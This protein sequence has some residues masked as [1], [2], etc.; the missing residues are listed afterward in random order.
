VRHGDQP[1]AEPARQHHRQA[2]R[3]DSTFVTHLRKKYGP[4][5]VDSRCVATIMDAIRT[6]CPTTYA[7]S[8]DRPITPE[9]ILTALRTGG[10]NKAPGSDGIGLDF[11]SVHWGTIRTDL[12]ELLNQM[13]LQKNINPQQKHG[14][15]VCLPKP[16]REQ[17]PEGFRPITLLN[18]DYKLLGRILSPP[19]APGIR[20][21]SSNQPAFL[22]SVKLY[23]GT[24]FHS[25]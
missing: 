19:S 21:S 20:G 2:Q 9:E 6:T 17:T 11:Y 13:F 15:I 25:T 23:P 8:L 16:N 3:Y 24:S 18:T 5:A 12:N 7:D 4:I 10:R 1:G 14:A 22:R